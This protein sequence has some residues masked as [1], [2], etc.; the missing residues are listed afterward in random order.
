MVQ[1]AFD[2]SQV[3]PNTG[4][5][6]VVPGGIYDVVIV[7]SKSKQTKRGDGWMLEFTY[8]IIEGDQAG[9]SL[10]DRLNVQNPSPQAQEI[11][12]GQ[13]SAISHCVGR[14][15][16]QDTQELHN[17][18]F[19][20]KVEVIARADDPSKPG[21]NITGYL[22]ADGR[23]PNEVVGTAGIAPPAPP[24]PPMVPSVAAPVAPVVPVAP[25]IAAPVAPVIPAAPVAPGPPTPP[26]GAVPGAPAV[27]V[28]PAAPAAPAPP[29]P[30][31]AQGVQPPTQ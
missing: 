13:L 28:P 2:A 14:L 6:D 1:M 30:P 8:K 9:K 22:T 24:A 17:L 15:A 7:D 29:K 26:W 11:A 21:N 10:L 18:P 3:A 23:P 31:W 16:W 20:V 27:P 4:A 19:K 5:M 25:Q 12:F